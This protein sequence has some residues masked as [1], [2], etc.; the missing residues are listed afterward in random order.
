MRQTKEVK[1]DQCW[2][3]LQNG[4]LK[5]EKEILVMAAQNHSIRTNL[6]KAKIDKNHEDSLSRVCRK[7]NDSIDDIGNGCSKLTQKECKIRHD[8]LEK[9]VHWKLARKCSFEAGDKWYE[10]EQETV[11]ENEGYK[12]FWDFSIQTDHVIEGWK[13]DLVVVDKKER[14]CKITNFAVPGESRIEE[15]KKNKIEKYQVLGRE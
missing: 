13:Q 1:S 14:N 4:D 7:L 11:S 10:R 9:I 12:I 5:R 6:V 3:W 2:D 8:N 15:K